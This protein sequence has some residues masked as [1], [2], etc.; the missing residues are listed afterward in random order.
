MGFCLS[1]SPG[2]A[3]KT[4][5]EPK[6]VLRGEKKLAAKVVFLASAMVNVA[7]ACDR[8]FMHTQ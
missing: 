3:L 5:L 7:L 1:A 4:I 8:L 2:P 6:L